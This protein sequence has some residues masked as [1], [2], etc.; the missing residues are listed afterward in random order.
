MLQYCGGLSCLQARV[1]VLWQLQ[2]LLIQ[3]L[4]PPA[5]P[6]IH[7]PPCIVLD[8][9]N[10]Q[11]AVF[12]QQQQQRRRW[13]QCSLRNPNGVQAFIRPHLTWHAMA[14][15]KMLGKNVCT[16]ANT[17]GAQTLIDKPITGRIFCKTWIKYFA[18]AAAAKHIVSAATEVSVYKFGIRI[19]FK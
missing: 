11:D 9:T 10:Q 13:Q 1:S 16:E 17:S 18:I 8:P 6:V 3:Q 14:T 19:L 15:N 12:A 7:L 2:E 4:V 5:P